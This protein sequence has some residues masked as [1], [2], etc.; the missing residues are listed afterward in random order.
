MGGV[1]M[2]NIE[3]L[4]NTWS[5]ARTFKELPYRHI[6]PECT[7]TIDEPEKKGLEELINGVRNR[8]NNKVKS[9]RKGIERGR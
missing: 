1:E 3:E 8:I 7:V 6:M 5:D 9:I 4:L 2:N